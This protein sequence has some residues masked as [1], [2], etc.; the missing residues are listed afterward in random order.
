MTFTLPDMF[1]T[2]LF[3][4]SEIVDR[5]QAKQLGDE[6]LADLERWERLA[7]DTRALIRESL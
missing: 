2:K 4:I 5:L 7:D 6:D 3:E 1:V